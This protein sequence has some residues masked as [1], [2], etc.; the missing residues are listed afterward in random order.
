MLLRVTLDIIQ[1]HLLLIKGRNTVQ[2]LCA[3]AS[4]NMR[5]F[6]SLSIKFF[7]IILSALLLTGCLQ[8]MAPQPGAEND[9]LAAPPGKIIDLKTA[10]YMDS[11]QLIK[12]LSRASRIIVG[13]KHDNP[14]HHQIERWLLVKLAE[15]RPQGSVLLEMLSPEQQTKVTQVKAWLQDAPVVR[16]SHIEML[17]RW[18]TGWPWPLYQDVVMTALRAPYPVLAANLE[19][20]E[21]AAIKNKTSFPQG[22]YSSAPEVRQSIR[23]AI[24]EQHGG[25][26]DESRLETMVAIQQHRDRA[27]AVQLKHAPAPALL[28]A[29]AFHAAKMIGVPLHY[30]DI[31]PYEEAPLVLLLAEEGV[32]IDSSIADIVWF[33][34][35]VRDE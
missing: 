17:L 14:I 18:N 25:Q 12:R 15:Q 11:N 16:D 10:Q 1:G 7:S 27:M 28:I 5:L 13:E 23:N 30:Q 9:S 2:L 32:Q 33:V 24:R 35:P 34:P 20:T 22:R 21:I 29:G 3:P 19:Q 31:S 6:V 4:L 8:K 26:I